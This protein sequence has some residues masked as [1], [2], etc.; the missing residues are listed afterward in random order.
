MRHA[1]L[2]GEVLEGLGLF[3]RIQVGAL[4]VLDE[5]Q[6]EQLLVAGAAHDA[7]HGLEPGAAGG[8]PAAIAGDDGV[9]AAISGRDNERLDNAV[10]PD[11]SSQLL[12]LL[13]AEGLARLARVADDGINGD[14]DCATLARSGATR[15]ES[16]KTFAEPGTLWH[17]GTPS[18]PIS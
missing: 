1:E 7:G 3:D 14:L 16:I 6:L 12:Q 11:G 9:G 13:F 15:D 5:R 17:D 4:D 8:L 18:L 2:F 10:L